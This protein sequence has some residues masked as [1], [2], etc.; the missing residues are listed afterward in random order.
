MGANTYKIFD[1]TNKTRTVDIPEEFR[2]LKNYL[3]SLAHKT[4]MMMFVWY[5]YDLDYCPEWYMEAWA[6]G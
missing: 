1:P 6:T 3:A 2:Y 5:D 4:R